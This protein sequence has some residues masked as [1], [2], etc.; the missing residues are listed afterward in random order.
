MLRLQVSALK[1]LSQLRTLVLQMGGRAEYADDRRITAVKMR[2][3]SVA[4]VK[5]HKQIRHCHLPPFDIEA[6]GVFAQI[7]DRILPGCSK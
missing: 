1:H 6:T 3:L 4:L 2:E 5:A 7:V